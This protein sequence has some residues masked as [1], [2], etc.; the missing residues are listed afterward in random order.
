MITGSV[1]L[2]AVGVAI[3]LF[4]QV[5]RI[6][7]FP[8]VSVTTSFVAEEDTIGSVSIEAEDNNDTETGFFTNDEKSSMIPQNG[9]L[10]FSLITIQPSPIL[11]IKIHESIFFL[12]LDLM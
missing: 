8:L 9:M 3:A 11:K 6:A 5:S 7:I 12:V 4:N 1:E 10:S 2:A